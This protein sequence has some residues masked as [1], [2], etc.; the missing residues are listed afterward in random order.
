MHKYLLVDGLKS[1]KSSKMSQSS[2]TM[3]CN[4]SP[5]RETMA[6]AEVSVHQL[7]LPEHHH[8]DPPIQ[9]YTQ[10]EWSQVIQEASPNINASINKVRNSIQKKYHN[11]NAQKLREHL[12]KQ[13]NTLVFKN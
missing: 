11:S 5:F 3:E 9:L 2:I 8:Q 10:E 7:Q 1:S 4:V 6:A 12:H 13:I